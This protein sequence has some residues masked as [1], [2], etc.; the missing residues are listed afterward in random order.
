MR[1][2]KYEELRRHSVMPGDVLFSKV[3]TIGNSCLLPA[4]V[5]EAIL[6]TTGSCKITVNPEIFV[7]EFLVLLI[8]SMNAELMQIASA[9]VQP[10]LN[11]NDIKN[12]RIP[13]PSKDEQV[14]IL[15]RIKCK[16]N[17][18]DKLLDASI[19]ARDLLIERRT[20]LISAAV[21]GKIDVRGFAPKA[22][23]AVGT[24]Q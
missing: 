6:S 14:E 11:M 5:P 12:L 17:K 8:Q 20:A 24:N 23:A 21:T 1:R 19:A 18:L 22:T 3:G 7:P 4:S 16:Q 15:R 9:N 13:C 10:F 2:E